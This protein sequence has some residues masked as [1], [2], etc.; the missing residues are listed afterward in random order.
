MAVT[1]DGELREMSFEFAPGVWERCRTVTNTTADLV[2]TDSA[3]LP[4]M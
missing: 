2:P 4:F 1:I 3:D